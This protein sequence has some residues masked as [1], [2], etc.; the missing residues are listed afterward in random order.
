MPKIKQEP[1]TA[2]E[3]SSSSSTWMNTELSVE[4]TTTSAGVGKDRPHICEGPNPCQNGGSCVGDVLTTQPI[5][6]CAPGFTND[7]CSEK[8][9]ENI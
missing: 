3:S 2:Y 6:K 4:S 9:G 7:F 1:S 5:C 8:I